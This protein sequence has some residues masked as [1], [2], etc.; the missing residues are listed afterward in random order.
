MEEANESNCT[1]LL[2]KKIRMRLGGFG[3]D[4]PGKDSNSGKLIGSISP[5]G[6]SG[7]IASLPALESH[8]LEFFIDAPTKKKPREQCRSEKRTVGCF[9]YDILVF[10]AGNQSSFS[11]SAKLAV[12]VEA[13]DVEKKDPRWVYSSVKFS[14]CVVNFKDVRKSLY[15]EDT[16]S[17]CGTAVDRGWPDLLSH[18]EITRENG[19]LDEQGRL[20]VRASVCVRQAD[21]ILMGSDYDTRKETG[22]IGLK[23]HGATCYLN[24]LLQSY[25]HI[26]KF[27]EIVYQM[28]EEDS[29]G[30][31]ESP[32]GTRMSLPLALQSVFLRLESAESAVNT[33]ELTRSF[34]WDSMDAFTQHDVQE[35]ARILCDKLEAKLKGTS[36]DR[37]IQDLFQ[38]EVENYIEC[39]DIEYK[40][41]KREFFYDVPVNVRGFLGDPLHSLENALK[42]FTAVEVMEGDNAYDAEEKGKQRAKK[43]I[44]FLRFPPVLSFQLK[45]F[46]FDYEKLDNVKLNDKFTFPTCLD[47]NEFSKYDLHTVLVHSGDVHSG[48]YY[49][50]VRPKGEGD[51]W[52]RFDDE[53]VS[54]CSEFAAVDDNF[55]GNDV[56]PHNFLS[57]HAKPTVRPRIHSA[58][59]LVYVKRDLLGQILDQPTSL[60]EVQE[61]VLAESRKIDQRKRIHE[62]A[63]LHLTLQILT[64]D[65]L[66]GTTGFAWSDGCGSDQIVKV[67]KD[68][69]VSELT[70]IIAEKLFTAPIT[71][72]NIALFYPNNST[73]KWTLISP[74]H[75][76][77]TPKS[78]RRTSRKFFTEE[79]ND[80][81]ASIERRLDDLD[82]EKVLA[83]SSESEA[84]HSWTEA[85]PF[86]LLFVKIFDV[87]TK[88]LK[89]I[90]IKH[91]HL[92]DQIASLIPALGGSSGDVEDWLAFEEIIPGKEMRQI[93]LLGSFGAERISSGAILVFQ[94]NTIAE[95]ETEES[96]E[97]E[98]AVIPSLTP[99]RFP[100]RTVADYA[101]AITSSV[102]AQ[103][104]LHSAS[105]R[106][107]T[108]GL[109]AASL[110]ETSLVVDSAAQSK[111]TIQMDI[112]WNLRVVVSELI[113]TL[114]LPIAT[115]SERVE[116]YERNPFSV[117][118]PPIATSE[119]LYRIGRVAKVSSCKHL[120]EEEST[121][122]VAFSWKLHVVVV[123]KNALCVRLFDAS[124]RE[125]SN[126]VLSL[127]DFANPKHVMVSEIVSRI[128]LAADRKRYIL[129]EFYKSQIAKLYKM[130]DFIDLEHILVNTSNFASEYLRIEPEEPETDKKTI[131]CYVSH[132]D[133]ASGISFGYPFVVHVDGGTAKFAKISIQEKFDLGDKI[134]NKWRLCLESHSHGSRYTHLKD[135]DILQ[136][137]QMDEPVRLVLEHSHPSPELLGFHRAANQSAIYKPLTIR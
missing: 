58:Y 38:G 23:N 14:V 137:S 34:G 53:Q 44:R 55:G 90:H 104:F 8:E 37:A 64:P 127:S 3:F 52:F 69:K 33:M 30:G 49:A 63:K 135:D 79:D 48:H 40:S 70:S 103:I 107:S 42:Q 29:S 125:T 136:S 88:I 111:D 72:R 81:E 78:S 128:N 109:Q 62:E 2:P 46:S 110:D 76:T 36:G 98:F 28:R 16:H 123:P 22:Y 112:R 9:A 85:T 26:G 83:V 10:P 57:P 21:T 71:A 65:D 126:F 91:A 54:K 119:D 35:L 59:M 84:L 130:E 92:D 31:G 43:G 68:L 108:D 73:G 134:W 114:K 51:E 80:E 87:E 4:S 15:H 118:D 20:C 93:E 75:T 12:Y 94:K 89:L 47:L 116:V 19:W 60:A 66:I 45:R 11:S 1:I 117:R 67:R 39:M 120:V 5:S 18:A 102:S 86:V 121:T 32:K 113:K 96:S 129:V 7:A 97:D 132:V 17:F 6:G 133:K 100:I 77:P 74:M 99:P 13:A 82:C 95:A 24:G 56:F 105:E 25:F 41:T 131:T 50:F 115:Q 27:R 124:V 122:P 61:R 106:I 101:H